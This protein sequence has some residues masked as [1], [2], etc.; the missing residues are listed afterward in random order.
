MSEI[1]LHGTRGNKVENIHRGDIVIVDYKKNIIAYLGDPNKRTF[2]RSCA[3]PIQALSVI[4][5]GAASSYD[6][7]QKELALMCA[8]H[9]AE[10]F[11]VD[12]IAS[13]LKKLGLQ[14]ENLLCGPTYSIN[15]KVSEALIKTGNSKRRI[16]NNCSGKHAGM[17]AI[18]KLKGYELSTYNELEH[19]LQQMMLKSI[20]EVCEVDKEDIGI[21]IDGCGVPVVE[22]PLYNMALSFAKLAHSSIFDT[23]RRNAVDSVVGAMLEYPEMIAGTDGFCT[24]LIKHTHGKMIGKLGADSVYCIGI[25]EH[26]IGIAV[27]IE[28]G[29]MRVLSCAVMEVLNQLGYINAQEEMALKSF[30]MIDII[31]SL[32]QKVGEVQPVFKLKTPV[33]PTAVS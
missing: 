3:K 22:I 31:N 32:N 1:L 12:T 14:E 4:E 10:Q 23:V 24:E 5:S 28:D 25:L 8:S 7:S 9:Y 26:G 6:I 16:Y 29:N 19:P 2:M 33:S 17:L 15:E 18:S 20:S 27:K 13:I 21:G 30:H 11:H